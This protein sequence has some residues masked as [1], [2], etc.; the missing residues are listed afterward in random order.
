MGK[1]ERLND[2]YQY[3]RSIGK[4]HTQ[5]DLAKTMN[6]NR[7]TISNALKDRGGYLNDDFYLVSVGL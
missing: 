1:V 7:V 3:L 6:A 2:A 5:T 4:I